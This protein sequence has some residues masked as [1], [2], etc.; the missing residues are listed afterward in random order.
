MSE[1]LF[2]DLQVRAAGEQP[3]GMRV[4]EV[5]QTWSGVQMGVVARAQPR[6]VAKPVPRQMPIGVASAHTSRLVE[7]AL[8]PRS[9]VDR[10]GS[11]AV[12]AP[13]RTGGVRGHAAVRVA[14][15]RVVGWGCAE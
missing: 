1:P 8:T 12:L 11:P 10:E 9:T 5:V 4:P 7:A 13:A 3:G 6:V 15:P 2:H 14:P